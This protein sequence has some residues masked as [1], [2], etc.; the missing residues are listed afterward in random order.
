MAGPHSLSATVLSPTSVRLTWVAPCHTQ[1]Y[2]IYYRG[3]CG[4]YTDDGKGDTDRQECTVNGLQE[5]MNYTFTV[6]QS[7]F[8]GGRVLSAGPVY[9][10]TFT[11]GMMMNELNKYT[12]Y[13]ISTSCILSSLRSSTVT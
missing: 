5:G 3:T 6:N 11:A 13:Q 12:V 10:K 7:G 2:H 8:S 9:A 1:Q 4:T